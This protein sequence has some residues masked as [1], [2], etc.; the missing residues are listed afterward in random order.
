M[1]RT[2]IVPD[3]QYIAAGANKKLRDLLAYFEYREGSL[4]MS[5]RHQ[6]DGEHGVTSWEDMEDI[7]DNM[8]AQTFDPDTGERWVNR[9]LGTHYRQIAAHCADLA[10]AAILARSYVF[11]PDP[12]LMKLVRPE[13]RLLLLAR[14][15][16]DIIE[17][18]YEEM[19][20]GTPDYAYVM[21]DRSTNATAPDGTPQPVEQMLHSHLI[22]PGTH[23]GDVGRRTS[24]PK[25]VRVETLHALSREIFERHLAQELGYERFHAVMAA[26]E[27]EPDGPML[28]GDGPLPDIDDDLDLF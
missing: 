22:T 1:T 26:R 11:S 12:R 18:L 8:P 6:G 24:Q 19:E 25:F 7:S 10:G 27:E 23:Y 4:R 21:H 20:W 2:S 5:I 13:R 17:T 14:T 3:V 16:E 15:T 28:L 9:G